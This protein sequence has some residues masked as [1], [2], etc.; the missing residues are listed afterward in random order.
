[1]LSYQNENLTNLL[2]KKNQVYYINQEAKF[3]YFRA[4]A[5]LSEANSWSETNVEESATAALDRLRM[6]VSTYKTFSWSISGKSGFIKK[7][8]LQL[9]KNSHGR[10]IEGRLNEIWII[11]EALYILK[12][13]FGIS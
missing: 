13:G 4:A 8:W 1:M 11:G 12:S 7:F 10:I 5:C 2:R 9:H 3:S 6:Q